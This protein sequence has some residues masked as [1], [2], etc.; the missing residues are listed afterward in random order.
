MA[1]TTRRSSPLARC[2]SPEGK[3][4]MPGTTRLG[5]MPIETTN[6]GRAD[7]RRS[8]LRSGRH[9]SAAELSSTRSATT[10]RTCPPTATSPSASPSATC[11]TTRSNAA[12]TE[13]TAGSGASARLIGRS[14][15]QGALKETGNPLD[16]AIEGER[17]LPGHA[18]RQDGAH[19]RRGLP[20]RGDGSIATAD[21]DRLEPPIK[22]PAGVSAEEVHDSLRRHGHRRATRSSA[23]SSS[24]RSPRPT[25]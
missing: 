25:T 24:S 10:S 19:P 21:G 2:R 1:L 5:L 12:G 3:A 6:T 18:R 14:E 20:A 15:T 8:L 17:L 23:R 9:G 7:A 22:V 16:L 13:T 11:S 4:W